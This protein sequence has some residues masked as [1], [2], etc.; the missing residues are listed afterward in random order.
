MVTFTIADNEVEYVRFAL[1][2]LVMHYLSQIN[3][4]WCSD[5]TKEVYKENLRIMRALVRRFSEVA[6]NR[7]DEGES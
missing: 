1:E 3:D 7:D 2:N 4:T 5:D 6:D